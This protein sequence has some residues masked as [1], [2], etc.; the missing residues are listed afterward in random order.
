MRDNALTPG[1]T[2]TIYVIF[3]VYHLGGAGMDFKIYIDPEAL[4]LSG[5]LEFMAENWSVVPTTA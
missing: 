2:S 1:N 3:R 5:Q 4:R